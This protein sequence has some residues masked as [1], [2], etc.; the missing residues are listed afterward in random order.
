MGDVYSVSFDPEAGGMPRLVHG[1]R[2]TLMLGSPWSREKA[3]MKYDE[4]QGCFT[5]TPPGITPIGINGTQ[6][7]APDLEVQDATGHVAQSGDFVYSVRVADV[8]GWGLHW[9]TMAT[10]TRSCWAV[11]GS[12]RRTT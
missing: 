2:Y 3:D 11:P 1:Q 7:M 6:R 10:A 8:Q 4:E 5:Y 12:A 9:S